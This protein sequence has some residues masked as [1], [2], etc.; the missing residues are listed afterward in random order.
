MKN[1][2]K[3]QCIDGKTAKSQC[4][5]ETVHVFRSLPEVL[6]FNLNWDGEPLP[7]DI[8]RIMVSVPL[9]FESP[10]LFARKEKPEMPDA[11]FA[12]KG[13]ICFQGAHYFSFFRRTITYAHLLGVSPQIVQHE[14]DPSLEWTLFD[15][16][17]IVTKGAWTDVIQQF[18][19]LRT[20]PTVLFYEKLTSKEEVRDVVLDRQ[21]F[22]NLHEISQRMNNEWGDFGGGFSQE[23]ML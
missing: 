18:V 14:L 15:D 4:N 1:I 2:Q 17:Q 23:E 20:Y 12:L 22:D 19:E 21:Q 10:R 8:F 11:M 9:K 16:D 6:T 5:L 7:M 3:G 13:V